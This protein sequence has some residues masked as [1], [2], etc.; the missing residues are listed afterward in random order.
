MLCLLSF[1]MGFVMAVALLRFTPRLLWVIL[2]SFQSKPRT[3][4]RV[5]SKAWPLEE[6]HGLRWGCCNNCAW[7]DR[8]LQNDAASR[9]H[10]AV[11]HVY[12]T[13]DGLRG[14]VH[15]PDRW[16]SCTSSAAVAIWR[17]Q[18]GMLLHRV[19]PAPEDILDLRWVASDAPHLQV[20]CRACGLP[21][22]AAD[23]AVKWGRWLQ[24]VLLDRCSR[25]TTV[26]T[27]LLTHDAIPPWAVQLAEEVCVAAY[28]R[29][30][31]GVEEADW[32][33]VWAALQELRLARLLKRLTRW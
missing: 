18:P 1:A 15:V 8:D 25:K 2:R 33:D 28:C 13:G 11:D 31:H 6:A 21:D 19:N 29:R 7:W 3:L 32:V 26:V 10:S 14:G 30:E 17:A 5:S 12:Y 23:Y 22:D 4:W 16:C 27:V 20:Q 9:L 24:E